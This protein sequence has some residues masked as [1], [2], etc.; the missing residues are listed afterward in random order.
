MESYMRNLFAMP[1]GLHLNMRPITGGL[2]LSLQVML[3]LQALV[4]WSVIDKEGLVDSTIHAPPEE[5]Q[6][7]LDGGPYNLDTTLSS[8]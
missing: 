4:L 6:G 5:A 7:K 3:I 2:F 1:Y 8:A